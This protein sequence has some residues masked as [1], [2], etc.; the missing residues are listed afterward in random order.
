[1]AHIAIIGAGIGG[2]PCAYDLRKRLG[3]EHRVTLS[4]LPPALRIHALESLDR[5]RLASTR[6]NA[7]AISAGRSNPRVS[8][9][10]RKSVETIDANAA[11]LTLRSGQTLQYDYL[12]HR[13]RPEAGLR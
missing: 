1:M 11:R 9:G 8:N 4:A 5:G 3:K 6:A 10:C 12:V 13:D 2:V 7:R